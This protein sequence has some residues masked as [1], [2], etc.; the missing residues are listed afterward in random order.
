MTGL[1]LVLLLAC[2]N[3]TTEITGDCRPTAH[4]EMGP[5]YR[6]NPPLRA[7]VGKG[8]LL[9]GTVRSVKACRPLPGAILEF[10]LANPQ[11]DYDEAHRAKVSTDRRGRYSFESNRPTDYIGRL[12]HI[13]IK[14]SAPGHETL[15][16]QH[17]PH[18]GRSAAS[19]DLILVAHED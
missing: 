8:Y 15:I 19:F 7:S 12:P 14:V 3:Q 10:W 5:F 4:D 13:H 17:Y 9:E 1:L 11:G 2:Q 16:T 18:T 6:P